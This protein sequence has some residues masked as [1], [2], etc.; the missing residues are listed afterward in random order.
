MPTVIESGQLQFTVDARILRELG[1]R[2]V[3]RPETALIELIKNAYDADATECAVDLGGATIRVSD[4]GHGMTFAQF[5]DGWMRI[6]TASK[7]DRSTS[8]KYGRSITG[9]KGIG[10]FSARFLGR[11]LQLDTV[12]HDPERGHPTLLTAH[13]DWPAYDDSE[14]IGAITVPYEVLDAG[15]APTGTTL[16]IGALRPAA[17]GVSLRQV[18]TASIG[19]VSPLQSLIIRKRASAGEE[20]DPGFRLVLGEDAD[21]D[22][23]GRVLDAYTLR[24]KLVVR[25]RKMH[26]QVFAAGGD[27]DP[28]FEI[29]DTVSGLCGDV[30]ADIRFFPRRAGALRGLGI[31][32][33]I[34]YTWIKTNSGVAV[35]DRDFRVSP[36]GE[37]RDDWLSLA[38]DTARNRRQPRSNIAAKHFAM[39]EAEE[40]STADNWMLRLPQS[41][42]L[43]GVVQV[44][45]MRDSSSEDGNE[46]LVAAADREGFID[47]DAFAELVD[48]A[49]GAVEA[50]AAC[51]RRLQREEEDAERR[52]R[53]RR[54]QEQAAAAASEVERSSIPPAEKKRLISAISDMASDAA[55]H[56]QAT[57]ERV[58][59]LEVMSLLGV[60]AGFMTHEF[61]VALDELDTVHG[62]LGDLVGTVPALQPA[63]ERMDTAR[64]R[65]AEFTDYASAYIRGGTMLPA[66]RYPSLPRLRL[67]RRTFAQYADERNIEVDA[68][69]AKDLLAPRV[70]TALYD[71]ILINLLTNALKA[72]TAVTTKGAKRQ[73]SF[74]A[75]NE[76]EWHFLEAADTGVGIPSVLRERV[77]D[78]LFTTTASRHDPLGSGMGLGLALVRTSVEAFGGSVRVVDPPNGFSTCVQVRLPQESGE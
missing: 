74:R 46:G 28:Y 9:E 24:A 59:Q 49:R 66:E 11:R 43:I 16:R 54:L 71:G 56:E 42:Q 78:P 62:I 52:E 44:A 60:I 12:A 10:R 67:V 1:E 47:N 73:I 76:K 21:D 31:D 35:F 72:V 50:I 69:I 3:R 20:K 45:G 4:D 36:Y 6:G 40:R 19:L 13:F 41:A 75:W 26:L 48:L 15:G 70:P 64:T 65:L 32:G 30:D 63:L 51:D 18:R 8:Q 77:F 58:R 68:H 17:S 57:Q 22:L 25:K 27:T 14:D 37:E 38:A 34:A 55:A 7:A 33:R 61:G 5:R 53:V 29:R 23:A 2:L 39:S